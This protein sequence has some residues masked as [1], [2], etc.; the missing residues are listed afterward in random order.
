MGLKVMSVKS[1]H[2]VIYGKVHI[3]RKWVEQ[4]HDT[5]QKHP[6]N[7]V[8]CHFRKRPVKYTFKFSLVKMSYSAYS[9][10]LIS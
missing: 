8:V 3:A 4:I 9:Q 6:T 5:V 2:F 10:L 1:K 7:Q